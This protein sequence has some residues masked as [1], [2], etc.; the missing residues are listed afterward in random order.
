MS[1]KD[2]VHVVHEQGM[3]RRDFLRKSALVAVPLVLGSVVLPA[4]A[5]YIPPT[6]AR[7]TTR[8]SVRDK[9]A[10]G[11][12]LHDDTAAFQAA[13][14]A[15]P[16]T[17]GT[18]YVPAGTYLIDAVRSVRLRSLMHFEMAVDAK[19]V[20]KPNS[21]ERSKVLYVYKIKDV[22]ISGGQ[23][24]GERD[25]H[26]GTTGEWGHAIQVLGSE[27]VTVRDTRL[28]R[29]WGDGMSIGVAAVY[30]AASILS[31]DVVVSNIVSTGNRRQGLSICGVIGVKVYDSEFSNTS[32]TKPECGIDIEP[33]EPDIASDVHIENCLVRG[34]AKYGILSYK[35]VSN[36]TIK[37]CIIEQNGSC[38][39]VTVGSSNVMVTGNGIRNNSA[40][41][42]FVQDGS[43]YVTVTGNT[44]FNNYNRLGNR[45]RIDFTQTGWSSKV[46]RD[47]LIR[48]V[49]VDIK[50]LTNYYQ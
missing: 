23:I 47:I 35:R 42:L 41:G 26:T 6:R 10:Y 48:G 43:K 14:N 16:S 3:P 38:G 24:V 27:R 8:I 13:V 46:E 39:L 32:G 31:K 21:S 4:S 37:N 30:N 5:A 11:D 33:S 50:I 22:E 45:D 25:R 2:L 18:V 29:C 17:G 1:D 34:N 36:V 9:G 20:A 44:F 19:L 7:G 12:G 40:T 28:S 49:V 15:L